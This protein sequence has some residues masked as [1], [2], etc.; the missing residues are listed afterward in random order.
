MYDFQKP[1][2]KYNKNPN[3]IRHQNSSKYN[4][5]D[6]NFNLQLK[7]NPSES[8]TEENNE[9]IEK[10]K[11]NFRNPINEE[12]YKNLHKD[13]SNISQNKNFADK[14][15]LLHSRN[16]KFNLKTISKEEKLLEKDINQQ[17]QLQTKEES[18]R[19]STDVFSESEDVII[20]YPNF[21]YN[22]NGKILL[23]ILRENL[24]SVTL[25]EL[26]NIFTELKKYNKG[27]RVIPNV[28]SIVLKKTKTKQSRIIYA[29]FRITSQKS[30]K[31]KLNNKK[32]KFLHHKNLEGEISYKYKYFKLKISL[33][34]IKNGGY[35]IFAEE[36]LPENATAEYIGVYLS[37]NKCDM[38][39]AWEIHK[40][41]PKSGEPD[42]DNEQIL[43]YLDSPDFEKYGNW[44]RMVNCGET[45]ESNNL[46]MSQYYNRIYYTTLRPIEKGEEL[47]VDYGEPY[48]K[49]NLNLE[50]E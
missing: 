39:Y 2:K 4:K 18:E 31:G 42:Y 28:D 26:E 11:L 3:T 49:H 17:D 1:T 22:I 34:T 43:Y 23:E 20:D 16:N 25:K 27:E 9:R 8:Y 19:R 38:V 5:D 29:L 35:G 32:E 24:N 21:F 36:K 40:Y 6:P 30:T 46:I 13:I 47:F 15:N 37:E 44:T 41:E 7:G 14:S 48:R 45:N 10:T 33:S 50:Y 12:Q